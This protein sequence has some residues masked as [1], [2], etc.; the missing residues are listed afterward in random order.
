MAP[1]KKNQNALLSLESIQ[2]LGEELQGSKAH[3]NNAAILL[4]LLLKATDDEE[5]SVST[6]SLLQTF[7][8]SLFVKGELSLEIYEGAKKRLREE[9][10]GK[11]KDQ[12][13]AIYQTWIWEKYN[14]LIDS[15]LRIII[16]PS[17]DSAVQVWF[18]SIYFS[19]FR[20]IL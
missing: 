13:Q 9:G 10:D 4:S 20:L 14:E 11:E 1:T 12:A 15:L 2:R 3:I 5:D 19:K 7:F 18:L 8:V 16:S 17:L 6:P